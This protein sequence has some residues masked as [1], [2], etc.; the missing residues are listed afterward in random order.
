MTPD[1]IIQRYPL[2]WRHELLKRDVILAGLYRLAQGIADELPIETLKRELV[3]G[4]Q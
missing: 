2:T 4:K 1:Q 3:E